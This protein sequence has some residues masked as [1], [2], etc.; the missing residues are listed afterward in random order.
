MIDQRE[1]VAVLEKFR[2]DAVVIAPETASRSWLEVSCLA[3]RDVPVIGAL[4]KGSSFALGL[5]LAQPSVKVIILDG[6][7]SLE[8]NLGSL[9]TIAEKKP[10]NL[11]HF[12]V[13]NG[14]Y[15][16]T[17]G[18]PIPAQDRVCFAEMAKGAGYA[19]VYEFDDLED[20]TVNVE[21]VLKQK[22]PVFVTVKVVPQVVNEP[23][24]R[25]IRPAG[26]RPLAEAIPALQKSLGI[27]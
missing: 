3:E 23:I 4:G 10:E 9:C 20:F 18:Q 2:G 19:A 5:A 17:G 27:S 16:T 22:G 24:S 1:M 7:G 25:R 15:A 11:H 8:I 13:Q 12:V 14:V 6:D 26:R 21:G